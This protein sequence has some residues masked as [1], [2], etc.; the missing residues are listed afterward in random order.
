MKPIQAWE[1]ND[2]HICMTKAEALLH[3]TADLAV[4]LVKDLE[5]VFQ[6]CDD[7]KLHRAFGFVDFVRRNKAALDA[8]K[9]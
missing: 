8:L 9:S 7:A 2:G 1:A 3:D 5:S 4:P 6:R